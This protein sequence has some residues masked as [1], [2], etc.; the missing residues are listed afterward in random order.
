MSVF[1]SVIFVIVVRFVSLIK[2]VFR[3]TILVLE[4]IF[5]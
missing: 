5:G 3:M 1:V 2:F 4:T